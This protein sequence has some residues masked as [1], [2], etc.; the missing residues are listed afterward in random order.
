MECL[1][2][3]FALSSFFSGCAHSIATRSAVVAAVWRATN[4]IKDRYTV[5]DL[6]LH[7]QKVPPQFVLVLDMIIRVYHLNLSGISQSNYYSTMLAAVLRT[8]P[9]QMPSFLLQHTHTV[10]AKAQSLVQVETLFPTQS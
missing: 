2:I 7:C 1:I 4:R 10:L 8:H 3:H 6:G 5:L 9:E